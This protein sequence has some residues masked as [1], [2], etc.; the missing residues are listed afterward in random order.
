[1]A[2][3]TYVPASYLLERTWPS[4][5]DEMALQLAPRSYKE[6]ATDESEAE[7]A[8]VI[9][10]ESSMP[11]AKAKAKARQRAETRE[12]QSRQ[13]KGDSAKSIARKGSRRVSR[14]MP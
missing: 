7:D 2:S 8:T 1:V 9:E 10:P 4:Q 6:L 13:G 14:R 3:V 5:S 12:Q 11:K